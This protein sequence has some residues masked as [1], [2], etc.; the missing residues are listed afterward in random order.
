MKRFYRLFVF[1]SVLSCWMNG[2]SAQVV[3][4]PDPVLASVLRDALD[5]A[6]NA[7]ITK[8][9]MQTL[10]RLNVSNWDIKDLTGDIQQK[11]TDLTGL[12][13]ATQLSWL[14]LHAAHRTEDLRPLSGL[15]YLT[16]LELSFGSISDLRP[17]SGLTRLTHLDLIG[18]EVRDLAPVKGFTQLKALEVQ[19]NPISDFSPLSGLTQLAQLEVSV[20]S[21]A[22]MENLRRNV[23]LTQLRRLSIIGEGNQIG[24]LRPFA[25][26][27]QLDYFV[28]YNA[29]IRDLTPLAGLT[30]LT[31]LGLGVNQIRDLT[32]LAGLTQLEYLHL[33]GNQIDNVSPLSGLTNLRTLGLRNNQI[34]DITPIKDLGATLWLEGNP[35]G[36][37][38][39]DEPNLVEDEPNLVIESLTVSQSDGK[40]KDK[41]ITVNPGD[42]FKLYVSFKN[43]GA[44]TSDQTRV[45]YYRAPNSNPVSKKL[46]RE[47]NKVSL[48]GNEAV[49][50]EL[51][52]TAPD[53]EGF[54]YYSACV[55]SVSNEIQTAD[56]C[57]SEDEAVLVHVKA[58]L[59]RWLIENV[60]HSAD[61]YTY[62]VV[63][64]P[65]SI[66][67]PLERYSSET[68]T[69]HSLKDISGSG[70]L[71]H[72]T[73][74][75]VTLHTPDSGYF[76]FPLESPQGEKTGAEETA[77]KAEKAL[78]FGLNVV[79][80]VPDGLTEKGGWFDKLKNGVLKLASKVLGL[81]NIAGVVIDLV[82]DFVAPDDPT[83]PPTLTVEPPS[84]IFEA[85]GK[86]AFE[87]L[88]GLENYQYEPFLPPMLFV[89]REDLSSIDITVVQ[90][91]NVDGVSSRYK[92]EVIWNLKDNIGAAPSAHPMSLADYPPFQSFSPE[93]QEYLLQYFG[94]FSSTAAGNSEAW[95]MPEETSLLPNYPNPFNPETWIPYQLSEP[96]DV[97]LTIYDIQGRVAR[98]LDLGHQRA[99]MYHNRSRSAYWDGRNA[100]GEPVASGIYFYT[101]TAGE[102]SATRKLLIRK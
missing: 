42:K 9:K 82:I 58:G 66:A 65:A 29:Q 81:L 1:L 25:N 61:G 71:R 52:V 14:V 4:I 67:L 13:H 98:D 75:S 17:L 28:V 64:P 18:N 22:L 70:A 62:F 89:I 100:V 80:M 20:T 26:L 36:E 55:D 32:P 91:Y 23:D 33:N 95:Q 19:Y 59:P 60:A 72:V 83:A 11:I 6:P 69:K 86:L 102:F 51:M 27:T 35:I 41:G 85:L 47:G 79:G 40:S 39:E 99:G 15:E 2:A 54:Y 63:N 78:K 56:N 50:M 16:Y 5:L 68:L 43:M 93:V 45:L 97:K 30:N 3:N 31:Y 34:R 74:C 49:Q 77:E 7:P 8:S 37:P 84:N 10:Y 24:D 38:S 46:I 76:M 90:N 73:K 92:W 87:S 57:S 12:E 101:L 44:A 96:A 21:V 48:S 53:I 94:E 88:L